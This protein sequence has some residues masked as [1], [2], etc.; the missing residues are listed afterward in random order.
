MCWF[1]ICVIAC[2]G[3]VSEI[4]GGYKNRPKHC[5]LKVGGLQKIVGGYKK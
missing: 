2:F 3:V 5:R 4:V 1:V